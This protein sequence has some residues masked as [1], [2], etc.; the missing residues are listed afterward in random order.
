[1]GFFYA[2]VQTDNRIQKAGTYVLCL[3]SIAPTGLSGTNYILAVAP[4][5]LEFGLFDGKD[6]LEIL[7]QFS[8]FS[9]RLFHE[10]IHNKGRNC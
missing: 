8:V 6:R 2:V 10:E 7:V 9:N 4:T 1:M 5:G 3:F